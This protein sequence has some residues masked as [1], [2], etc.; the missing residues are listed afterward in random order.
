[1]TLTAS[2][3]GLTA[4]V[5]LASWMVAVPAH[6]APRTVLVL[7]LDGNAD[8]AT[9]Q[10]LNASVLTAAKVGDDRVT[11]G[12]TTFTE[13]AAAVGCDA[14]VPAC[15]ESVRATLGVDV[16]VHGSATLTDGQTTLVVR[17]TVAKEPTKAVS[18]VVTPE[19]TERAEPALTPLMD[20]S[21][22]STDL[23]PAPI[24]DQ[25]APTEPVPPEPPAYPSGK[26]TQGI[27]FAAGGGVALII[28]LAL[29]SNK[30]SVQDDIDAT[31]PDDADDFVR[32]EEL[33]SRAFKYAMVGNVMVLAGLALGGYGGWIL[34]EDRKER[35]MAIT[36]AVTP[37]S[38]GLS[39]G[40]VW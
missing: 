36:P 12:D 5:C 26:R 22:G 29:W 33:E 30:A 15:A 35:R 17:R 2:V 27:L 38:A 10:K 16:L 9:R 3:R 34:W 4:F 23:E 37:T 20:G 40:G 14:T 24:V 39:L 18:V 19:A 1:M 7:P 31:D 32:L 6:A 11:P 21:G 28:G 25:P 8:A 13:T